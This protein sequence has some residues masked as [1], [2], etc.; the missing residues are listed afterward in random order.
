MLEIIGAAVITGFA[1]LF[2]Y[3]S[4]HVN[5]EQKQGRR[6][7]LFWE[8]WGERKTFDKSDV[9]YRDGDNT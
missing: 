9:E 6:L 7:P 4:F 1:G 5:E 3:V 8:K 2:A